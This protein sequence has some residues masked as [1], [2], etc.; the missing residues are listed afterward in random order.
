[1]RYGLPVDR[2]P[3]TRFQRRI[4]SNLH[5]FF[6]SDKVEVIADLTGCGIAHGG[7]CESNNIGDESK[8]ER[9]HIDCQ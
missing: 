6:G 5:K 9:Q 7:I 3:F 1:M 2:L 4:D 8:R